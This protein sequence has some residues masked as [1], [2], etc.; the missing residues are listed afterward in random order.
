M[1]DTPDERNLP[2]NKV[3]DMKDPGI[4]A[5]PITPSDNKL[6]YDRGKG[7][8]DLAPRSL[9]L[10]EGGDLDVT[11]VA[12]VRRVLVVPGGYFLVRVAII[13]AASMD[14]TAIY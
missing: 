13:H 14:V 8:E 1:G 12:G 10:S 11:T 2:V 5:V 9:L 3:K 7:L 6:Q 4:D